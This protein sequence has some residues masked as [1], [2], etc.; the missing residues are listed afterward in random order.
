MLHRKPLVAA[1]AAALSVAML[2]A[3]SGGTPSA[4]SGFTPASG[5]A[6][7]VAVPF[8]AATPPVTATVTIP[9]TYVNSYSGGADKGTTVVKF[10]LDSKTGVY[11]VPETIVSKTNGYKEVLNSAIGFLPVKGGGIGQIILS[12]NF[13][14]VQGPFS[15]TGMDTYP[16]GQ[17]SID[18]PLTKGRKWSGAAAHISFSNAI[19]SGKGAFEQNVSSDTAADGTY[20]G[21]TSYSSTTGSANQDNYGS[22][23]NTVLTGN[24]VYAL[25]M[26]A[27]KYNTVTQT[28][29]QPT[30]SGKKIV[31]T[32]SGKPPI[33]G[34]AG[35]VNVPWWYAPNVPD[36]YDAWEVKGPAQF[37]S[38][39]GKWTGNSTKVIETNYALDPVQGTYNTYTADYYLTQIAKGQY[40]FA[41]IVEVYDNRTYANGWVMGKGS[42]GTVVSETSGQ[43]TLIATGAKPS[44]DALRAL[45]NLHVF[46]FAPPMGFRARSTAIRATAERP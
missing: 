35:K 7:E 9:Y 33:P 23:T 10:T 5:I 12:D 14:Y 20:S 38:G 26:R 32:T 3:C 46:A 2:A 11:Y 40:W 37:P 44:A 15:Q 36:Y 17:N 29:S 42:D 22:T 27:T 6:P 41:C 21:Q 25:S 4:G 16:N 43:E 39:C 30:S 1:T 8:A 13:T 45:P 34:K 24:S 28:F 19:L 31:V 18:F